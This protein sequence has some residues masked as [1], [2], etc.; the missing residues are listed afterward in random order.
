MGPWT[1]SARSGE[2]YVKPYE[3]SLLRD[4]VI[5]Q[6]PTTTCISDHIVVKAA[7]SLKILSR[8]HHWIYSAETRII[9]PWNRG[10]RTAMQYPISRKDVICRGVEFECRRISLFPLAGVSA[11]LLPLAVDVIPALSLGT[12]TEEK[13]VSIAHIVSTP[14]MAS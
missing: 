4:D 13:C 6:R 9:P 12:A 14:H 3:I 11:S 8:T 1:T 7:K 10:T 2:Y 5:A